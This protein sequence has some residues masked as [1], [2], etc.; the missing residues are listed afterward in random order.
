M[1]SATDWPRVA[2]SPSTKP[3][4][5]VDAYTGHGGPVA[6]RNKFR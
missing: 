4:L 6:L 2:T 1:M 3:A 5:P